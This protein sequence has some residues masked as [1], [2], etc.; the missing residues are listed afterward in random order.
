MIARRRGRHQPLRVRWRRPTIRPR[1]DPRASQRHGTFGQV[2][3]MSPNITHDPIRLALEAGD[4]LQPVLELLADVGLDFLGRQVPDLRLDAE[5]LA[6]HQAVAAVDDLAVEH[7]DRFALTVLCDV[8]L[9]R[10]EL[11]VAEHRE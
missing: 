2:A 8:A 6:R 1:N 3:V 7:Q 4:R 10:L 9:E 11:G 5:L